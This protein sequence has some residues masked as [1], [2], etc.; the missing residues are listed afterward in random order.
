ME[1]N[2]IID[3]DQHFEEDI[4]TILRYLKTHKPEE[5]TIQEAVRWRALMQKLAEELDATNKTGSKNTIPS[6]GASRMS[7]AIGSYGASFV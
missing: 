5:A 6:S 2:P 7:A 4:K 3:D 1:D